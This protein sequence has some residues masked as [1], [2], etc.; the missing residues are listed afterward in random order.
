MGVRKNVAH[1]ITGSPR[2]QSKNADHTA[3]SSSAFELLI[4]HGTEKKAAGITSSGIQV[5]A[6]YSGQSSQLPLNANDENA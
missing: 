5:V 4:R 3:S 2:K 1:S 6:P